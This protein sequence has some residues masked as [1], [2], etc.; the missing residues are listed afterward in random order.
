MNRAAFQKML[1]SIRQANE[2]ACLLYYARIYTKHYPE[3]YYGW[4]VLGDGLTDFA[5]YQEADTALKRAL[6]LAPKYRTGAVCALIGHLHRE[7]GDHLRAEKWY[8]RAIKE[9]GPDT[10]NLVI[11]GG[12]LAK[13]GRYQE[14]RQCH[15]KAIKLAT[16]PID[17]ALFN[18]GLVNR[19]EGR[20]QQAAEYFRQTLE[21]DPKYSPAK[22]ALKD[23]EKVLALKK[24]SKS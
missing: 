17:E 21:I 15:H 19:A 22:R 24:K 12:C 23:V 7:K 4:A 20:L 3:D 1:V 18:L 16:H 14:A 5:S 8:R 10:L 13:Q 6:R 11:L 9:D 2:V